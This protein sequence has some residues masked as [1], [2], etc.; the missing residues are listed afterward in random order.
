MTKRKRFIYV[1]TAIMLVMAVVLSGCERAPVVSVSPQAVSHMSGPLDLTDTATAAA[2]GLYFAGDSD[3]GL[4]SPA[5]NQLGFSTGGT[6]RMALSSAGV[7][8][9]SGLT[10]GVD[11]TSYDVIFYSDTEGDY[12][13]WDQD[14]EQLIIT[15]TNATTVLDIP[16]GNVVINDDLTVTAGGF[17]VTAGATT[18][19]ALTTGVSGVGAD[20]IFHSDTGGEELTWDSSEEQLILDGIDS[21]TVLNVTDGDIVVE[22]DL[23]VTS[24][25]FDVTAGATT[26]EAL[27]IG[28]DGTSADVIFYSD[29]EGDYF[30][31]DESTEQLIITGTNAATALNVTDG[32]VV[33]ADTLDVNTDIDLDGTGFDVDI[34]GGFSI[35]GDSGSNVSVSSGD[36]LIDAETGSV[37]IVGSEADASSI[38]LDANDTVTSGVNIDVGSVSGLQIDGGL[39]DFGSG[40]YTQ[41][42]GDGDVGIAGDL[43]VEGVAYLDGGLGSDGAL[44]VGSSGSGYDVIFYSDSAGDYFHWDTSDERLIITGTNGANALEIPDGNVIITLGSLDVTAGATTLEALTTGV[45]GTAAD[46]TFYSDTEGDYFHWDESDERLIITGTN[47][48]NAL[49]I[50]DGNVIITLGSL[51]VTAGATTLEALTVGTS[52]TGADVVFHSD[53]GGEEFTWDTSEEQLILDGINA[54]TV[55]DITD[56]NVDI[57]DELDVT[58]TTNLDVVDIDGAVDL[59]STLDVAGTVALGSDVTLATDPTG[60]NAGAKTEFIGLPRITM[61]AI[62]TMGNG[63]ETSIVDYGDTQTQTDDWTATS[64]DVVLSDQTAIR[65]EGTHALKMAVADAAVAEDGADNPLGSGDQNWSADEAFGMWFRADIALSTGDFVL[66]ITDNASDAL[67]D[68]PAYTTPDVW[69]WIELNIGGTADGD[70]DAITDISIELSTA[71]AAQGIFNAYF[72]FM[73]KWDVADEEPLGYYLPYDGVL[74]FIVNDVTTG[75]GA[76]VNLVEYTSYFT[77]YQT[78][79][80]AVV[81]IDDQS[82]ANK[83]GTVLIAY[84][85]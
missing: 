42:N 22:D 76:N 73:V 8:L 44:T 59:D 5:A 30:H 40:T 10:V 64:G 67:V 29:T 85:G 34:S 6:V 15:G 31:W 1:I 79:N 13:H 27:T 53:T 70:K 50:P 56:G 12:L 23:T 51:D 21:T 77:H 69:V 47:G 62:S 84:I 63:G 82:N 16:D 72:D 9:T 80:D 43:E 83:I 35:D 28:V 18:L 26:L 36:I 55:L 74:G 75:A 11:G 52:G 41:A 66:H 81:I 58:G 48:A 61:V 60:G 7:A 54:T 46:V 25:T 2:P 57:A 71:G 65:R 14:A 32:N 38:Y 49:E 24:G 37:T 45:D 4:Y 20:V 3:T 39:T 68:F 33:I 19:E 17:D 78:G